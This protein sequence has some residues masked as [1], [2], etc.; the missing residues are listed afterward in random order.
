MREFEQY[1]VAVP[2]GM[3]LVQSECTVRMT[4]VYHK[5]LNVFCGVFLVQKGSSFGQDTLC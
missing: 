3:A 2:F 1:R 5:G 4:C